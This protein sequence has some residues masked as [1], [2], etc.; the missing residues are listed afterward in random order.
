MLGDNFDIPAINVNKRK[1]NPNSISM[2]N[3]KQI[4]TYQTTFDRPK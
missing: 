2:K 4:T 3:Q 1:L